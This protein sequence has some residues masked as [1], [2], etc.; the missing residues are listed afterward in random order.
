MIG[1]DH[2]NYELEFAIEWMINIMLCIVFGIM[3]YKNYGDVYI[4]VFTGV[5]SFIA[6][7]VITYA[8]S[9]KYIEDPE[10]D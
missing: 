8:T 1:N 3:A 9:D 4:S 2:R 6:I 5:A 7:V 10:S